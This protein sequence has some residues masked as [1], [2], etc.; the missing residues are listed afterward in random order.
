MK[1][2][3]SL[4]AKKRISKHI[5]RT[6]L[7]SNPE[8]NSIYNSNILFK[9]ENLQLT[10]SFKPRGA[11]NKILKLNKNQLKKGLVAYSSGNHA[12]AVAYIAS[13]LCISSKIIMPEDA[14]LIKKKKTKDYGAEIILFDKD[15]ITREEI[16]RKIVRDENRVLIKPYDDMDIIYGQSTIGLEIYEELKINK[17][18]PDIVLCSCGGGGLIAGVS[19]S[20]KYFYP[21]VKIYAIEPENYNDMSKSILKNKR[22]K[23]KNSKNSIC[24][25]LMS[26]MP[27]ELTFKINKKLLSGGITIKDNIAKKAVKEFYEKLKIVTEPGGVISFAAILNKD[28]NVKNK[29]VVCIISGSNIDKSLFSNIINL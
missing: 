14:S 25:A 17:I 11:L 6:P 12:Q 28:I 24:D 18:N 5:I 16:A 22:I 13:M 10:G 1:I 20:L 2:N 26:S 15:K 21:K 23:N 19:L 9:L 3:E 4:K 29:N 7:Y 27:G 8:I